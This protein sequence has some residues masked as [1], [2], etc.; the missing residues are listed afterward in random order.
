MEESIK[1]GD[2]VVLMKNFD[3]G[4]MKIISV[5][6]GKII[7]YGKLHFDSSPLIGSRFGAVFEIHDETMTEVKD[8]ESYDNELSQTLSNNLSNFNEKS[9]FSQEKIIK[10]KKQKNRSNIVT[11]IRPSLVL[12]NEML[13]A[14]DKIGGLR[15]DVLSQIITLS[16]IHCGSK[17]LVLDH[18]LGLVTS[19]VMSRIL[20]DGVCIQIAPDYEFVCA[21]RTT[22]RMLNIKEEYCI[23]SLFAILFKDFYKVCLNIDKFSY[24]NEIMQ[25]KDEHHIERLTQTPDRAVKNPETGEK[26]TINDADIDQLEHGKIIQSLI[27]KGANREL[28]NKERENASSLLKTRSLNSIILIAQNDHPLPILKLTYEF[29]IPS[30][31]FVIYSDTIEPLLECQQYLKSKTS[32]VSMALS[33]SWL[34]KY[35]V[36]PDRTRPEM[37]MSGYGG[38]LLSGTKVFCQ[39][40][41]F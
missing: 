30:G 14:R 13:Y 9:Q 12:I 21:T 1:E 40:K 22:L 7:H 20:P 16:N 2:H 4:N 10:K 39:H 34:R 32:A 31:Q 25:T 26:H 3:A 8:F 23:K 38:Y 36:L 29:L 15:P 17:C 19:A 6:P 27:K 33:E 11:L 37:N 28:R 5:E 41:S 18:N 24:E 35:Q